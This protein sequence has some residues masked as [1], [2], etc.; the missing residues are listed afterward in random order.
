MIVKD[1]N[2]PCGQLKLGIVKEV[3]KGRDSLTIGATLKV[4]CRDRQHCIL[5][6][7]QLLY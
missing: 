2:H 3:M 6:P 5:R 1:D 7:V 4:A